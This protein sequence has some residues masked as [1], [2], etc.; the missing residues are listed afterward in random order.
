MIYNDWKILSSVAKFVFN[1]Y[2]VEHSRF[3]SFVLNNATVHIFILSSFLNVCIMFFNFCVV[4]IFC[5]FWMFTTVN[6]IILPL[7]LKSQ[8]SQHKEMMFFFDLYAIICCS[9]YMILPLNY[10]IHFLSALS[11]FTFFSSVCSFMS[12]I[13]KFIVIFWILYIHWSFTSFMI[14]TFRS[15]TFTVW[16][17]RRVKMWLYLSFFRLALKNIFWI[18]TS[19]N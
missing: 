19:D 17:G 18:Q 4:L 16:L 7:S 2:W 11:I 6:N 14:I 15:L 3:V 5:S 9:Q 1:F 12:H 8:P 10:N 13:H